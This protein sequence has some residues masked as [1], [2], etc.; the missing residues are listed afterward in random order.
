MYAPG[1]WFCQLCADAGVMGLGAGVTARAAVRAEAAAAAAAA[2]AASLAL[3][4]TRT[5]SPAP[6]FD[7][8]TNR[9]HF[10]LHP[11][12]VGVVCIRPEGLEPGTYVQDY[13]G[14]LYS[15]W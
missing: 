11:K 10:R 8:T 13:L 7:P 6:P 9:R 3:A 14:E 15:P 5:S 4:P 1:D 2:A 12:G